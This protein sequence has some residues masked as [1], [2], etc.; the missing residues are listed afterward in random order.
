MRAYVHM[1]MR[2]C[3]CKPLV[4]FELVGKPNDSN[5]KQVVSGDIVIIKWY[6]DIAPSDYHLFRLMASLSEQQFTSYED[7]KNWVDS[8]IAQKIRSSSDLESERCLKATAPAGRTQLAAGMHDR[9]PP[10]E[11]ASSA[12]NE[13]IS[14]EWRAGTRNRTRGTTRAL[15]RCA[16]SQRS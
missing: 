8:W 9:S 13:A 2:A 1:C 10:T 14:A 11:K 15:P 7:T 6:L 4:T 12:L 5:C 16:L 3:A